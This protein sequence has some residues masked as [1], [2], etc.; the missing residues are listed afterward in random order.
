MSEQEK[1]A[2]FGDGAEERERLDLEN[3]RLRMEVDAAGLQAV[4]TK[5]DALADFDNA[6]ARAFANIESAKKDS[7]NPHFRNKYAD[8]ASVT[9]AIRGPLTAEGFSWP[10]ATGMSDD[11]RTVIV[12]TQLRRKGLSISSTLAMPVEKPTAQ[13]VGSAITYARRY[14]L[15][16]ITGVCPDDDD[17]N[18]A[19]EGGKPKQPPKKKAAPKKPHQSETKEWKAAREAFALVSKKRG[20][21][22]QTNGVKGRTAASDLFAQALGV[23]VAPG[24]R[25]ITP[26]QWV[27]AARAFGDDIDDIELGL[28]TAPDDYPTG[29]P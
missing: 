17:G 9:D 15:S 19:S 11:G 7:E 4:A 20:D 25:E 18:A 16:A 14:A 1:V 28:G 2:H 10:Q 8:L 22:I 3:A 23:K 26:E 24:A 6:L 13:G 21:I 12:T 5:E 29:E 27:A